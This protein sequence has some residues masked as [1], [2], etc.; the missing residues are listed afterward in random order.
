M[1]RW[2]FSFRVFFYSFVIFIS[3]L[4][5]KLL[6]NVICNKVNSFIYLD[7]SSVFTFTYY[8][9]ILVQ[10]SNSN[11]I[12]DL[13]YVFHNWI[14]IQ[15]IS[16]E[17]IINQ[18]RSCRNLSH[19]C[20]WH[21]SIPST[22]EKPRSLC[23]LDERAKIPRIFY[24]WMQCTF[25][26]SLFFLPLN[27]GYYSLSPLNWTLSRSSNALMF[28][29]CWNVLSRSPSFNPMVI[30]LDIVEY[31]PC[32]DPSWSLLMSGTDTFFYSMISSNTLSL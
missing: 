12:Y 26:C 29:N 30:T 20:G 2:R 11:S 25:S 16:L 6:N 21:K 10:I 19:L 24:A 14:W 13:N 17:N 18:Q 8:I 27:L 32:P 7:L 4:A 5:C 22:Q 3:F 15:T 28:R 23:V 1:R 31:I 9:Y